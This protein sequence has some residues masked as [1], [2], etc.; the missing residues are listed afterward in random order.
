M[1]RVWNTSSILQLDDS[2]THPRCRP[3]HWPSRNVPVFGC[4]SFYPDKNR[5]VPSFDKGAEP[6]KAG[7]AWGKP[8]E[9]V[10]NREKPLGRAVIRIFWCDIL[11]TC[12]NRRNVGCNGGTHKMSK[13]LTGPWKK[14]SKWSG[15]QISQGLIG[16]LVYATFC[17]SDHWEF[18]FLPI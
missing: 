10:G 18:P 2:S 3:R 6:G 16:R 4:S 15:L 13:T 11:W 14:R 9:T 8:R 1:S 7:K 12:W 5:P 17:S